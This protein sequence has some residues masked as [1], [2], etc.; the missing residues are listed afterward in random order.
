MDRAIRLGLRLGAALVVCLVL[1][2]G[3]AVADAPWVH[4]QQG[5]LS[6]IHI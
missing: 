3:P 4:T 1:G 5:E 2:G 6:L